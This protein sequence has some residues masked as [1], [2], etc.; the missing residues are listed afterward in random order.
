MSAIRMGI[1]IKMAKASLLIVVFILPFIVIGCGA[2]SDEEVI[3]NIMDE[4]VASV[5]A[6]DIKGVVK[7]ISKDFLSD[8]GSTRDDVKRILLSQLLRGDKLSVFI[9][10]RDVE[11][12]GAVGVVSIGAIVVLGGEVKSIADVIPKDATGLNLSIVFRKVDGK[13]IAVGG[14]WQR[15]RS[16]LF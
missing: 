4:M 15:T 6:K 7:Y 16:L 3:L 14:D 9:K 13:W 11:L 8:N 5:E 10:S 2:A 12:S 1:R